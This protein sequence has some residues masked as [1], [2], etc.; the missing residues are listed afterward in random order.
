[1]LLNMS[2]IKFLGLGTPNLAFLSNYVF[3]KFDLCV[4]SF[5]DKL[6]GNCSVFLTKSNCL[7]WAWGEDPLVTAGKTTNA[8]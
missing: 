3:S 4:D 7:C 2:E 6:L 1:M 8:N 5:F